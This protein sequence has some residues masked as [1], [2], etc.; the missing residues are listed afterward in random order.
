MGIFSI[1]LFVL[2]AAG[3]PVQAQNRTAKADASPAARAPLALGSA[4]PNVSLLIN[5]K[6]TPLKILL[7]GNRNLVLFYPRECTSCDTELQAV[8]KGVIKELDRMGVAVF[9]VSPDAAADQAATAKRLSLPYV[10]VSDPDGKAARAFHAA[11]SAAF[12]IDTDGTVSYV[13]NLD[14]T[15]LRGSDL[16]AAAKKFKQLPSSAKR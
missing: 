4:A 15:P 8:D 5:G 11:G 3:G 1:S 14:Q 16:I 6:K 13:S 2:M 9:A 10:L 12:M 7:A